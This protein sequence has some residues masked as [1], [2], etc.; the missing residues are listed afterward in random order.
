MWNPAQ[1]KRFTVIELAQYFHVHRNTMA[2]E[3]KD[4]DLKDPVEVLD[5]IVHYPR[6]V[7]QATAWAEAEISVIPGVISLS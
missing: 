4:V 7:A 1:R 5:F 2:K 3:L 6:S